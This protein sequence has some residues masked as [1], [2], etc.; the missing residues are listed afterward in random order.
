MLYSASGFFKSIVMQF[1]TDE[2]V[3]SRH[4]AQ[5]SFEVKKQEQEAHTHAKGSDQLLAAWLGRAE[6]DMNM[7]AR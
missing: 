1:S 6:P 3:L 4:E 2:L 5:F 7:A